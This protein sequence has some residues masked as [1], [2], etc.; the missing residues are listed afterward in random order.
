MMEHIR[1]INRAGTTVVMVC[2]DMEVVLDF[3]D[4]AIVMAQG[5]I[6]AD[7]PVRDIFERASLLPPQICELSQ[8]LAPVYPQLAHIYEVD[9]MADAVAALK[10]AL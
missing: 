8:R 4:R 7:G 10:E 6:I 1:A 9:A 2:H 3:A 5:G